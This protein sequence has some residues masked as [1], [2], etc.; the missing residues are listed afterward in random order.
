MAN[1]E[2]ILEVSGLALFVAAVFP[3]LSPLVVIPFAVVGTVVFFVPRERLA[4]RG[5]VHLVVPGLP[6]S[7]T[8][9]PARRGL[10]GTPAG[11]LAWAVFPVARKS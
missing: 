6:A 7:V 10:W 5:T 3:G 4:D 2:T 8:M 1:R 11:R 9:M